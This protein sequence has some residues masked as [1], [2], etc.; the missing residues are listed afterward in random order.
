MSKLT[1][2]G[3]GINFDEADEAAAA[4]TARADADRPRTAIGAISASLALG[5]GV[6]AENRRLK[7][8]LE[9]FE[10]AAFVEFID[11]K[12]ILPS[13]FANR[14]E[15][16]FAGPEFAELKAQIRS[17][18]RNVQPIKVRRAGSGA[19]EGQGY[20]IVFGH[21]RHRACLDL[22][23]P[24]A[25]VVEDLGDVELFAEMERENRGRENLSAWEQGTMYKRALE[26]GLFASQRQ[27]A[28]A[29]GAQSGNV[30]TAIQLASLPA[31]VVAAFAS[32]LELQFRWAADLKAA[33]DRDGDALLVRAREIAALRPRPGPKDVLARLLGASDGARPTAFRQFMAGGKVAATW[34]Q[35]GKGTVLLRLK[36]DA[37]TAAKQR[38]LLEFIEKLFD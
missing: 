22:G 27:L 36:P 9:K 13:R 21:R 6:E 19:D 16:S 7:Q 31:E 1:E 17:A 20:E 35:D 23:M 18:G 8:Q 29:I 4:S 34:E 15:L 32:P 14:H 12:R 5:R 26:L 10:D 33:F 11:P 3:K 28:S 25:A 38:R 24:V 30:S 37:L 2:K